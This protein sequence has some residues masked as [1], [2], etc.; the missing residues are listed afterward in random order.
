M[1]GEM[2]IGITGSVENDKS[3]AVEEEV[4]AQ[5]TDYPG[6]F[7]EYK[8]EIIGARTTGPNMGEYLP[9]D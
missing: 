2:C 8:V 7:D 3:V 6:I 4:K 5:S 9:R 1:V